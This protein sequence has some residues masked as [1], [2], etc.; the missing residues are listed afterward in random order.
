MIQFEKMIPVLIFLIGSL[1]NARSTYAVKNGRL[2]HDTEL[3]CDTLP[4]ITAAAHYNNKLLIFTETKFIGLSGK[5][6]RNGLPEVDTKTVPERLKGEFAQTAEKIQAAFHYHGQLYL[7]TT[8]QS[9]GIEVTI[10]HKYKQDNG[11]SPF[12][13]QGEEPVGSFF[14][15]EFLETPSEFAAIMDVA[16]Q[17]GSSIH[18]IGKKAGSQPWRQEIVQNGVRQAGAVEAPVPSAMAA[19]GGK[20][21]TAWGSFWSWDTVMV[22]FNEPIKIPPTQS[23]FPLQWAGH[24]LGCPQNFCYD[25]KIDSADRSGDYILLYRGNFVWL[26]PKWPPTEAPSG[27]TK[28]SFGG[29][30]GHIDS[31]ATKSRSRRWIL[32]QGDKMRFYDGEKF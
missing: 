12:T 20:V 17:Q 1:L 25:T 2:F 21:F 14:H 31:V 19:V 3:G 7:L 27:A 18:I 4:A 8:K 28:F 16:G 22:T 29:V 11:S 15:Y 9:A 13:Y 6:G 30:S 23:I 32:F 24:L 26:V 10:M 5:F